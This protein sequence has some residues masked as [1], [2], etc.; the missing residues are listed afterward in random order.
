MGDVSG[1][2]FEALRDTP[3]D[4]SELPSLPRANVLALMLDGRKLVSDT[5]RNVELSGIRL[6]GKGLLERA[7]IPSASVVQVIV[8]K[9]DLVRDAGQEDARQADV[10]RLIEALAKYHLPV[11]FFITE[12]RQKN[13]GA[14]LDELLETWANV[15]TEQIA[16]P[17]EPLQRWSLSRSFHR[18]Q[19]EGE[20]PWL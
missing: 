16:K 6:L 10:K 17:P 11:G 9:W 19:M 7:S 14:G 20:P 8:A 5:E 18:F 13:W 12:C 3:G 2:A 15:S 1:E 4:E